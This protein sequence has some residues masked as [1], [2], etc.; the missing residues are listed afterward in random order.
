MGGIRGSSL[1]GGVQVGT[2]VF[3]PESKTIIDYLGST[4]LLSGNVADAG[5]IVPF[6]EQLKSILAERWE[7][8]NPDFGTTQINACA[9][10]GDVSLFGGASG[11][12]SRSVDGDIWSVVDIGFGTTQINGIAIDGDLAVAVGG[13]G[14]CS[15]STDG[16]ATWT[17]TDIGASTNELSCVAVKGQLV[18]VGYKSQGATRRSDDGGQT[19][20]AVS[21]SLD[22]PI[23]IG[24]S[25]SLVAIGCDD[26]AVK[27][28]SDAGLTYS[29][30]IVGSANVDCSGV[31]ISGGRIYIGKETATSFGNLYYS[32]DA[33]VTFTDIS[34]NV[35]NTISSPKIA[36]YG[37]T[38]IACDGANISSRVAVSHDFGATFTTY[39]NVNGADTIRAISIDAGVAVLGGSNG[40]A[41]KGF[42]VV[43]FQKYT[44]NLFMRIK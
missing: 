7:A 35:P 11:F 5:T 29:S 22:L 37:S 19:W 32:D 36:A 12:V 40:S 30:I 27:V 10:S 24:I 20:V 6:P 23:S 38:V 41:R 1:G 26:G 9:A 17:L 16:G 34:A 4:Y 25:D 42:S 18:V 2:G 33:G 43:G 14:K 13:A 3:L 28:S 15:I 31:A 8:I 21:T 44:P 39:D